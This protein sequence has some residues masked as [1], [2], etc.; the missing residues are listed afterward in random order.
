M[1][2]KYLDTTAHKEGIGMEQETVISCIGSRQLKLTSRNHRVDIYNYITNTLVKGQAK[3]GQENLVVL[4]SLKEGLGE[5]FA[6]AA[7]ST[8]TRFKIILPYKGFEKDHWGPPK[9]VGRKQIQLGSVRGKSR[10]K[11]FR[12]IAEHA[13]EIKVL[14]KHHRW[15]Q[16]ARETDQYLVNKA[17]FVFFYSVNPFDWTDFVDLQDKPHLALTYKMIERWE[18]PEDPSKRF[19][20]MAE[21]AEVYVGCS[22]CRKGLIEA[23][24]PVERIGQTQLPCSMPGNTCATRHGSGCDHRHSSSGVGH[25]ASTPRRS[26]LSADWR[27]I[28]DHFSQYPEGF[29]TKDVTNQFGEYAGQLMKAMRDQGY[30]TAK[31]CVP[32]GHYVHWFK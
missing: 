7:I 26:H 10:L 28:Y 30:V 4:T 9:K 1:F 22:L 15:G 31:Q 18:I 19:L 8:N 3:Y 32:N 25:R 16:A 27:Q 21:D 13:E 2:G 12:R 14:Y 20:F 5:A 23:F 29:K 24:G 6:L 11:E 17:D